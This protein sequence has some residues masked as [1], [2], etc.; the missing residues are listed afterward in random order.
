MTSVAFP[1][2]GTRY[3]RYPAKLSAKAMLDGIRE[4][5]VNNNISN[6]TSVLILLYGT[7]CEK[8]ARVSCFKV[9][10]WS[11]LDFERT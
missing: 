1:C 10:L 5:S 8:I 9:M 7:D 6:V 11:F 3:R 2:L 4:F